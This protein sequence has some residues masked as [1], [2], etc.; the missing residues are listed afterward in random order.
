MST[1][2]RGADTALVLTESTDANGIDFRHE[3]HSLGTI[4]GM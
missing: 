1:I 3:S 4:R 2:V